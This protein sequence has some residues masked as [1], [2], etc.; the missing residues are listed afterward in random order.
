M[1]ILVIPLAISTLMLADFSHYIQKKSEYHRVALSVINHKAEY[2]SLK[3][4]GD[5]MEQ[6]FIT[7]QNCILSLSWRSL[8]STIKDER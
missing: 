7:D 2:I 8:I 5:V 6:T 4:N 1:F 3:K